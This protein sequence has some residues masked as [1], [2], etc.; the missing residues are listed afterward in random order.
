MNRDKISH[1]SVAE[2]QWRLSFYWK[3]TIIDIEF[4]NGSKQQGQML[5]KC[6]F[7]MHMHEKVVHLGK[8]KYSYTC[9]K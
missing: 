6:V 7:Y 8:H 5:T 3:T 2:N 9:H 4:T 1:L